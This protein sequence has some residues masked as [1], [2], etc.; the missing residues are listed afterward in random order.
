MNHE[1]NII[2]IDGR[3]ASGK[4]T[5]AKGWAAALG[6]E[7]IHMDDFFLPPELRTEA[8]LSEPGGNIHYE[9]F[10]DEVL[11][12]L[13][14]NNG[15]SYRVFDCKVMEY[16]SERSIIPALWIIVEGAYSHHPCFGDYMDLRVFSDI[17][18]ATQLERVKIRDGKEKAEDFAAKWIPMEEE[19]IRA[20]RIHEKAHI[21]TR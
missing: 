18:S 16:T 9:R 11:S 12:G 15:F 10:I 1:I 8:R 3:S 20:F 21:V 14:E 13:K 4:T 7:I 19:Y 5:M 6:A 17:D 2:A